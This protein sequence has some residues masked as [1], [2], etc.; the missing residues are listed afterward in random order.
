MEDIVLSAERELEGKVVLIT[1]SGGAGCGGAITRRFAQAGATIIGMEIHEKR[2]NAIIE[3]VREKYGVKAKSCVVDI[4]DR[5]AVDAALAEATAEFGP[6][7]IL[8]NNAAINVQK[9]TFDYDPED[10][11]RV[12]AVDF[13]ACWYLI[14]KTIGGMRDKG[15]GHIVNISSIAGYMG[16]L[17]IEAPY[18]ASKAALHDLTRGIAIE[19]G[20]H[21][22]R[23]NGIALGMI[24]S[25]FLQKD[26]DMYKPYVEQIPLRRVGQPDEVAEVALFLSTPKSGFITGEIINMSGGQSLG[27]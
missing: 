1:G 19:G 3:E 22:I 13:T 21:N 20:P 16:G 11:D 26:W 9:S 8:V 15:G 10:F 4:A 6:V 2:G 7:D 27:Q 24:W 14:R 5:A 18:A 23:C 17:G 25:K 12:M